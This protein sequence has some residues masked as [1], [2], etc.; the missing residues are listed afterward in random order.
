MN[1]QK[2]IIHNI[3]SIEDAV[4]DFEAKPLADSEVFLISGK[5]GAGK[6][7]ILD[8]ICLALYA[9]TPRLKSTQ[10]QGVTIDVDRV[11]IDDPRQLMRRNTVEAHVVLSFKGN[12]GICYEATW[13]VARAYKKVDRAVKDKTWQIRN[14]DTGVTISKK[15]EI[16]SEI[17]AAVGLDFNQFCRTTML[18]QGEFTRFLNSKD[19]EKAAILE[20]ITG[21]DIYSKIGAKVFELTGI[22]KQDWL[23]AKSIVE[24][25]SILT[26]EEISERNRQIAELDTKLKELK[27]ESDVD[28]A[29]RDWIF[30]DNTLAKNVDN[31]ADSLRKATETVESEAFKKKE[32]LINDWNATINARQWLNDANKAIEVKT[33]QNKALEQLTTEFATILGGM[34]Y[35]ENEAI[36]V[37]AEIEAID[38]FLDD[39]SDKVA[40]YENAQTITGLLTTICN[41]RKDIAKGTAEIEKENKTLTEILVPVHEAALNQRNAAKEAF[42]KT[43]AEVKTQEDVVA[44][45]NLTDLRKQYDNAKDLLANIKTTRGHIDSLTSAK[46]QSEATR[47]DLLKRRDAI[48]NKKNQMEK[49]DAPI[50]DAEI[51]MNIRKDALEKQKDTV[52]KFASALRLKLHK[53]DTCPICRQRIEHDLPHEEE[54][55]VLV[56]GLQ[57]AFI[58]AENEHQKLV[59]VQTR[60]DAEITAETQSYERDAKAHET[61]KSVCIAEAKALAA[62]EACGIDKLDD[63]VPAALEALETATNMAMAALSAKIK[64]GEAKEDTVK[65]LR[66]ALDTKRKELESFA[67]KVQD[68]EKAIGECKG[69]ISNVTT[70]VASKKNDVENAEQ[71]LRQLI[72]GHWD[73]DWAQNPM[74]F[75]E[76]LNKAAKIYNAK[77]QKKQT[78]TIK[79]NNATTRNNNVASVTDS[80]LTAIPLWADI[81]A[82]NPTP[83][84]K[85]LERANDIHSRA[86][87][88]MTHMKSADD[89]NKAYETKLDAFLAANSNITVERLAALDSYSSTDIAQQNGELNSHRN[90]VLAAT[91]LL[92][93]AR[94]LL[95]EHRL[96]KPELADSDTPEAIAERIDA[97]KKAQ[98]A[99]GEQK[100]AINQELKTDAHNKQKLS[101]YITDANQKEAIYQKWSRLNQLIGDST[102]S[103]FRKIAQSYVL[104]SLIHS[105]NSYMKTLTDRYTLKVN[106]GT[107]V[108]SL[109]DAYQGFVSRAASTI[110]GGESFLVSL[111]LA[112]ALSDIGQQWQVNTLFIDE[113]FGTLSGEPLQ[114]SI[115]TLRSL[116]S[117]TGRHVG[118]ISH[119][120]ELQERIPVQIQVI[121]EGNTS[122]S[123]IRIVPEYPL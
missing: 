59:T 2:L 7:T 3:A 88:A 104:S 31:A 18:A 4:I 16:E 67:I 73:I 52:N 43:E 17:R 57:K 5:T 105:A 30:S 92:D 60:L 20:K 91:T 95:D 119:V 12:N 53:G 38:K 1:L 22:R 11:K 76:A 102:G 47:Q 98:E 77:V 109:E 13:A 46:L 93:N 74:D 106:P 9:D 64:S 110:S 68:A 118:I 87:T 50:H 41:G 24:G 44:A 35:A 75:S 49:L 21:V 15:N 71:K 82:A 97:N 65:G 29:K 112:L 25:I 55:S 83:V 58:E 26:N 103:K 99:I 121:Q 32:V 37:T 85:L 70:L 54:L 66:K 23:N 39:E 89:N 113:G 81:V 96:K 19:D 45:L 48:N 61:D 115:E 6:S 40:E 8:A 108:I 117:K 116:H 42:D 33:L 28:C 63:T 122:S 84:D 51:K 27:V 78:L 56:D 94:K 111:S 10:M 34:K 101:A 90:A 14:L 107:F 69:L 36:A 114:K 79:L 123:K 86:I 120:E 100:G 62:C 72:T 80:I